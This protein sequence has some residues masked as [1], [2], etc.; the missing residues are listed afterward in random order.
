MS[1]TYKSRASELTVIFRFNLSSVLGK[2]Y[3]SWTTTLHLSLSL[4]D[5]SHTRSNDRFPY[6]MEIRFDHLLPEMYFE[7]PSVPP[8]VTKLD[9][10]QLSEG[11]SSRWL[12]SPN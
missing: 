9:F 7:T 6:L 4:F 12:T 3:L 5:S 1:R 11:G 10:A 2:S 8:K